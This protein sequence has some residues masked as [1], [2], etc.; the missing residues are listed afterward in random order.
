MA[1][2]AARVTHPVANLRFE[3]FL[4]RVEGDTITWFG[5]ED[6]ASTR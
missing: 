1:R 5:I 4:M 6:A 2:R 3:R